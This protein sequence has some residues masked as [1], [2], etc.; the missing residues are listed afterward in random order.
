MQI[1]KNRPFKSKIRAGDRTQL[2]EGMPN[3]YKPLGMNLSTK[4]VWWPVPLTPALQRQR[5]EYPQLHSGFEAS[6]SYMR[7]CLKKTKYVH[8]ILSVDHDH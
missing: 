3:R 8:F 5:Q 6:Q 4:C 2:V 7:M 1:F